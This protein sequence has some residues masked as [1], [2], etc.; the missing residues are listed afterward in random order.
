LQAY[1]SDIAVA[2]AIRRP[3]YTDNVAGDVRSVRPEL[4]AAGSADELAG[5]SYV[6]GRDREG[7]KN[8]E[9]TLSVSR[10]NIVVIN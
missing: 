10:G 2:A 7:R 9:S 3:T 1:S 5:I 4:S 6:V 8:M